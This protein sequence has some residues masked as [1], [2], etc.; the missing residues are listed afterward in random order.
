MKI[1]VS[2]VPP[3]SCFF[4]GKKLRKKLEDGKIATVTKGK[5][6][7]RFPK[8]DPEVELTGCPLEMLGIG[9]KNHPETLVQ[10]GDG[11]PLR[12]KSTRVD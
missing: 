8:G 11:N 1:R 6:R 7:S 3:L 4:Q 9:M 10:I 12:R 5:V 2:D